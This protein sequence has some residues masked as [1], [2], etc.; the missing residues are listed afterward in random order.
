MTFS[1]HILAPALICS[2]LDVVALS[3]AFVRGQLCQQRRPAAFHRRNWFRILGQ[4]VLM[5]AFVNSASKNKNK[6]ANPSADVFTDFRVKLKF[7]RYISP[8]TAGKPSLSLKINV[9]WFRQLPK[10]KQTTFHPSHPHTACLRTH[11]S[12]NRHWLMVTK[13]YV[14]SSENR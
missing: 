5:N 7:S 13:F 4:A 10:Q 9:N 3:L 2:K 14:A 1:T 8:P 11:V 6:S 12:G